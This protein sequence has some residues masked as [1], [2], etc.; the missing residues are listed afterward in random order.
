MPSPF[1]W[2]PEHAGK[3][4][5]IYCSGWSW[6][7]GCSALVGGWAPARPE[8]SRPFNLGVR[9][10]GLA[11]MRCFTK[12]P[13]L[14]AGLDGNLTHH[15][16]VGWGG[17]QA[18]AACARGPWLAGWDRC[19]VDTPRWRAADSLPWVGAAPPGPSLKT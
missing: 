13:P 1:L 12:W 19:W 18:V 3:L 6:R 10:M 8:G 2:L 7:C 16:G 17:R 11:S 5:N 15:G 4:R 14:G 9:E